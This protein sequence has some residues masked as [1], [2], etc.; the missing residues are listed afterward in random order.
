MH[1]VMAKRLGHNVRILEQYPSLFREGQAAG[2]STGL[3]GQNFLKKHDWITDR[4]HFVTAEDLFVFDVNLKVTEQRKVTF[5]LTT[6]KTLYYRLRANFDEL[7][8]EYAASVPE[9]L[10]TDGAVVYEVGKRVIDVSYTK[11][12]GLSLVYEDIVTGNS[13]RI[14]PDLIIAADG[15]NSGTRKLMFPGIEAPYAGY[16]TWRGMVPEKDVSEETIK[17]LDNIAIRYHSEGSYIVGY[18]L[19]FLLRFEAVD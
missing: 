2:L 16:L 1:G 6:W 11:E 14:H 19:L 13:S 9:S 8:S 17:F 5:K 3:H 4:G 12:S 10:P 7:S 15:A 18:A